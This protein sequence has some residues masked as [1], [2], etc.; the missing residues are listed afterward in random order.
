[1]KKKSDPHPPVNK[2]VPSDGKEPMVEAIP[3][4]EFTIRNKEKSN[5]SAKT[6][7]SSRLRSSSLRE[8]KHKSLEIQPR[9]SV[10]LQ[11]VQ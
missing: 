6:V 8:E 11:A 7:G 2:Y 3:M 9:D 1:M 4:A 5:G 10:Y